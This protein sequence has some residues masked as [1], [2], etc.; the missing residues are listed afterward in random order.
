MRW[1]AIRVIKYIY[2]KRLIIF[3]NFLYCSTSWNSMHSSRTHYWWWLFFAWH[4]SQGTSSHLRFLQSIFNPIAETRRHSRRHR[5][6]LADSFC[7]LYWKQLLFSLMFEKLPAT[8]GQFLLT[9]MKKIVCNFWTFFT[10]D[11]AHRHESF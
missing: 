7:L 6:C 10:S 5:K 4:L 1:L 8:F 3:K 11:I 9:I 2:I